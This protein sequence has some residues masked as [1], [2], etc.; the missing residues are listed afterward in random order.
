MLACENLRLAYLLLLIA[1]FLMVLPRFVGALVATNDR[2]LVVMWRNIQQCP[3]CLQCRNGCKYGVMSTR[4]LFGSCGEIRFGVTKNSTS[5]SAQRRTC[6]KKIKIT[7]PQIAPCQASGAKHETRDANPTPHLRSRRPCL[8]SRTPPHKQ[9]TTTHRMDEYLD[10]GHKCSLSCWRYLACSLYPKNPSY[11][12]RV[13]GNVHPSWR[14]CHLLRIQSHTANSTT[15]A[16]NS[17][18]I[19]INS[20]DQTEGREGTK[21]PQRPAGNAVTESSP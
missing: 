4:F 13:S 14:L 3:W 5:T 12:L 2:A 1:V 19:P 10:I 6:Q 8:R 9:V 18:F 16:L 7:N 15:Q 20:A 17:T 21:N 11:S